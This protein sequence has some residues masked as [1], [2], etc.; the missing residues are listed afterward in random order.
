VFADVVRLCKGTIH[1]QVHVWRKQYELRIVRQEAHGS[2]PFALG[3]TAFISIRVRCE[4][5][6]KSAVCLLQTRDRILSLA[7]AC[8]ISEE[9]LRG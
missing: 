1:A 5:D 9:M 7:V 8:C 3:H 4:V 6:Q 2:T